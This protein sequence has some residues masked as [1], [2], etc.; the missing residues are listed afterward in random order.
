MTEIDKDFLDAS[1]QR[2]TDERERL[3]RLRDGVSEE[4]SSEESERSELQEL[5]SLDQHPADVGSELFEREKDIAVIGVLETELTDIEVALDR[6]EAGSYGTCETCGREIPRERL[7]ALPHARFCLED[8]VK[9]E[10][11]TP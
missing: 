6:I 4:T 9:A 11:S 7:E 2:L 10:R 3:V 1:R 8:Q 5:S